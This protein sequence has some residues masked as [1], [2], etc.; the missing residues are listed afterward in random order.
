MAAYGYAQAQS[1]H[2][3]A[4][5]NKRSAR[6]GARE[7]YQGGKREEESGRHYEQSSVFHALSDSREM[8]SQG[9]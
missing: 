2:R 6:N 4:A 3:Y 7:E 9:F 5:D 1:F 8:R